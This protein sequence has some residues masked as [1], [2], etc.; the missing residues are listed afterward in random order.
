MREGHKQK[1]QIA[2]ETPFDNSTNGYDA[3]N[4]QEAIEES[5]EN[6]DLILTA[7]LEI[8]TITQDGRYSG[9]ELSMVVVDEDGKVVYMSKE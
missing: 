7:D 6:L 2:E 3:D 1:I 4:V 9:H 5:I 8:N